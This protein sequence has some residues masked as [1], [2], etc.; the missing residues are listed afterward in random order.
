MYDIKNIFEPE[1]L[2]EA[3]KLLE[4]NPDLKII[5]GGT[6]VLIRLHHGKLKEA[7][8]LS[9]KKIK[10]LSNI[11]ID[12]DGT[13]AIGAAATFSGIFRNDIINRYIPVLGD[14]VA[15]VGGPQIRNVATIGGNI[16]NGA[17]SA[18]SATTLFTL[19]AVL[20]LISFRGE[21]RVRVQDFYEGPG[22]VRLEAGE[23][24]AAILVTK[25]NYENMKG[26]YIKFSNRKALDIA[27]LGV[28]VLCGVKEGRFSDVRIAL[29]VAA[30]TPIRCLEAEAYAKGKEVSEETIDEIGR[31]ALKQ[32]K[33]RDSW[34][35]SRAYREHLIQVLTARAINEAVKKAGGEQHE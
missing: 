35:A 21:R 32:T 31:L 19:N 17:V 29:G 34:R 11:S 15:S 30:P 2:H 14:A 10:E 27:M 7:E 16:C 5:S 20:K 1:A 13:I 8:L 22:K 12:D 28:S 23:I 3:V 9:I 33:A 4:G 18:D 24:L 26:H 6:D 25:D